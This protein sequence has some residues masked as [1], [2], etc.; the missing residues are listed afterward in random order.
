VDFEIRP[1]PTEPERETI[2]KA[3]E[4]LFSGEG[5]S[6]SQ[7]NSW[8]NAGIRENV[9]EDDDYA[10]ARPRSSPGASRA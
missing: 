3:L 9:E 5:Q 10:T 6:P 2:G 4:R 8:R 7:A 1:E